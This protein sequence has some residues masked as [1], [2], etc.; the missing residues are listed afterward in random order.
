MFGVNANTPK[1]PKGRMENVLGQ[2]VFLR[3]CGGAAAPLVF[4]KFVFEFLLTT[5]LTNS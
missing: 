2:G 4:F 3:F 5:L 1:T